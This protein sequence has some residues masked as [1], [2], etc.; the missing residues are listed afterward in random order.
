MGLVAAIWAFGIFLG[1]HTPDDSAKGGKD[2]AYRRDAVKSSSIWNIAALS[3][4]LFFL[5]VFRWCVPAH[6]RNWSSRGG[7]APYCRR[8][9]DGDRQHLQMLG[10]FGP[11]GVVLENVSMVQPMTRKDAVSVKRYYHPPTHPLVARGRIK[12]KT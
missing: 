7:V 2:G 9:V 12:L 6:K 3:R 4:V 11:F 8:H 10:S 1:A 5:H